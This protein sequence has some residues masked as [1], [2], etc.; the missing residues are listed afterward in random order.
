MENELS[1]EVNEYPAITNINDF[2]SP[3]NSSSIKWEIIWYPFADIH[4][5]FFKFGDF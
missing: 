1:G 3:I 4:L 5:Y 2:P